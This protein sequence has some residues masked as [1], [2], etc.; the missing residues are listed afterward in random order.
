MKLMIVDDHPAARDTIRQL[1]SAPGVTICECACGEEAIGAAESFKPDWVTMDVRM[2]ELD[3]FKT[4]GL[5]RNKHPAARVVIVTNDD[6]PQVRKAAFAAGAV[7][8]VCKEKFDELR[9][10]ILCRTASIENGQE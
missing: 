5:L 1:L 8:Y 2:G 7:G 4:T 10:L 3:G 6:S 9:E